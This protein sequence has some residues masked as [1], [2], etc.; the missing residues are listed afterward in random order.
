RGVRDL[1]RHHEAAPSV[2]SLRAAE[3]WLS[4]PQL[5]HNLLRS[6]AGGVFLLDREADRAHTCMPAAA[7]AL[8]DLREIRKLADRLFR[9][10]IRANRDLG[11]KARLRKAN[12]VGAMRVQIVRDELVVA[13]GRLIGDVKG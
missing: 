1:Q 5:R 3:L 10:W 2:I 13:L 11:A 6:S 7:I 8:T 4:L 12:V 9:P